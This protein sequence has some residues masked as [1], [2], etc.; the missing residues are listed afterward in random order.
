MWYAT[1][2]PAFATIADVA[3]DDRTTGR[4]RYDLRRPPTPTDRPTV[5]LLG[6][7]TQTISS[8]GGQLR[9]LSQTRSVLA[10]EAR[11]QGSTELSLQ[12]V[13]FPQHARDFVALLDAL[14]LHAPVD[15]C[16]FS[17]GGRTALSIAAAYPERVRRLV[18]TGVGLTRSVVGKLIV[19][20]W[21]ATLATGSLEALAR[22][23]LPD[24]VGETFLSEHADMVEPMVRAVVQR[25]SYEGVRA[26][27]TQTLDGDDPAQSPP[28]L[29]AR[30]RCPA[31]VVSGAQDRLAPRSQAAAL[32]S[33]LS[34]KHHV[35]ED[36]GHTVAIEAA[37]T[38]RELVLDFLDRPLDGGEG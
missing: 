35:I 33:A 7:M 12:D 27:L 23:S 36:V 16:G 24:I 11:G 4:I 38:W 25:N 8:W 21:V 6:G 31:L 15:L 19:D 32:A 1:V 22:V 29:V 14:E 5:V 10:Y 13:S 2:V 9:P 37:T 34:A 3:G 28:Q 30:I 20:G 26:L 17:F 18:L